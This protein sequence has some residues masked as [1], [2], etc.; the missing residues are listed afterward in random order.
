MKLLFCLLVLCSIGLMAQYPLKFDKRLLDC[1]NKW[2]AYPAD[3]DGFYR[4]GFVYLDNFAGLTFKPMG[5]F[6]LENDS[7]KGKKINEQIA[8]IYPS[9]DLVAIIPADKF[10][11]L[12]LVETPKWLSFFKNEA[13]IDRLFRL[14]YIHNQWEEYKKAINYLDKVYARDDRYP[15]LH[16]QIAIAEKRNG[17]TH[18]KAGYIRGYCDADKEMVSNLISARKIKQAENT[19]YT[20]LFDCPDELK[21][22][23][24][25]YIIAF[26][27]YKT[28]DIEKFKKWDQ[29]VNRWVLPFPD[30]YEKVNQM[31][32]VFSN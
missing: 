27:Y 30:L 22:A 16:T 8:R 7:F 23:E 6:K 11:E 21:K 20:S 31:R 2:I 26:Q 3:S 9:K 14:G 24:M 18:L 1:E 28:K 10:D 13:Y 5:L 15:G 17:F 4:F 12:D 25:A 32:L 19:Y 29:E